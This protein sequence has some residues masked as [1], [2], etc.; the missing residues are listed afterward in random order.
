MLSKVKKHP[1][2][3]DRS[4]EFQQSLADDLTD[5]GKIKERFGH[6]LEIEE[7]VNSI[8][9]SDACELTH[10]LEFEKR[11][12]QQKMDA[13]LAAYLPVKLILSKLRRGAP[14]GASRFTTLLRVRFA[15]GPLHAGLV[16]GNICIEWDES[17]LVIPMPVAP[18]NPGDFAAHVGSGASWQDGARQV[19][20]DMSIANRRNMQTPVKLGIIYNYHDQKERLIND[21]VDLIVRYNRSK[22]YG[23]FRCNCQDF[24][25]DA[26]KALRIRK[27]LKFDGSLG[28][29]FETLKHGAVASSEFNTHDQLDDYVHAHMGTMDKREMEYLLCLY[30]QFH[31]AEIRLLR[32]EEEDDWVC[33]VKTCLCIELDRK[34]DHESLFLHNRQSLAPSSYQDARISSHLPN[35]ILPDPRRVSVPPTTQSIPEEATG[36]NGI[37]EDE[38]EG[39]ACPET[40]ARVSKCTLYDFVSDVTRMIVV[41]SCA[42]YEACQ[43]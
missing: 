17:S 29:Y 36:T 28:E 24:V 32:P 2:Y 26:L 41:S 27:E 35:V 11:N 16:V 42:E 22:K 8:E 13:A 20:R 30:F 25:K 4:L 7:Y 12:E 1:A 5:P 23:L 9:E 43:E 34:I 39:E 3:K 14:P 10:S 18:D 40:L 38:S 21:L 33:P 31:S 19:V 37:A 6:L 15:F